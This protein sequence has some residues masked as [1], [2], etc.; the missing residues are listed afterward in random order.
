MVGELGRWKLRLVVHDIFQESRLRF[1][2]FLDGLW[3]RIGGVVIGWLGGKSREWV[4]GGQG[5]DNRGPDCRGTPR[6]DTVICIYY[7][8][9]TVAVYIICTEY[10]HY[11]PRMPVYSNSLVAADIVM[12]VLVDLN[13]NSC[14]ISYSVIDG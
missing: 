13:H 4:P 10:V 8:K 14:L 2:G 12:D 1:G 5:T 9:Y 7:M 11:L 3:P 6:V